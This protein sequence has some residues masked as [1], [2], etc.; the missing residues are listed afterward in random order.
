MTQQSI[1]E[2][3]PLLRRDAVFSPCRTYRYTLERYWDET[4]PRY[5][6]V[7]LNPSTADA[8][9]DD[10]TNVR[11]MNFTRTWGGGSC[12]FVNL[13]AFR[14]PKPKVMKAA[15]EP[16]GPENGRHI[17]E[18]AELAD[19]IVV[20]WGNDGVHRG[21]NKKVLELLEGFDLWCLGRND[22]GRGE[23]KHP[24]YLAKDL[25]LEEF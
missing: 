25:R 1:F 10:P 4:K 14:S 18:Q 24:L 21:R 11:G 16:V 12:I 8:E 17:L 2:V 6:W 22:K 13:F 19:W 23:P 3:G 5:L 15:A 9:K 20:A 7:L